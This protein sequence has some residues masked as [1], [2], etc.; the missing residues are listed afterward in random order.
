MYSSDRVLHARQLKDYHLYL[1]E[2]EFFH[3]KI[4]FLTKHHTS[5]HG[6][7]KVHGDWVISCPLMNEPFGLLQLF[8]NCS[9]SVS[10]RIIASM[11]KALT[12]GAQ[13]IIRLRRHAVS[14][15][16]TLPIFYR[17]LHLPPTPLSP[18]SN[19]PF[20]PTHPVSYFPLRDHL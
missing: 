18:H 14:P 8:L 2:I 15:I 16:S 7:V 20:Q 10:V 1:A 6:G 9:P 4:P 12:Y 11:I 17:I 13:I 19:R 3:K 5:A